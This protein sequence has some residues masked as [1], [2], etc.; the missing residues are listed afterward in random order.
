LCPTLFYREDRSGSLDIV[1]NH[2]Q[3]EPVCL[4]RREDHRFSTAEIFPQQVEER[5]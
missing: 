4:L 1:L 5:S 2:P 3:N